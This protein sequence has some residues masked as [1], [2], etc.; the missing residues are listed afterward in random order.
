MELL[1][2]SEKSDKQSFGRVKLSY[3]QALKYSPQNNISCLGENLFEPEGILSAIKTLIQVNKNPEAY[4]S[5]DF[6]SG[7]DKIYDFPSAPEYKDVDI[8]S[9]LEDEVSVHF[10]ELSFEML[11][12]DKYKDEWWVPIRDILMENLQDIPSG[13]EVKYFYGDD[14]IKGSRVSDIFH[15]DEEPY[16]MFAYLFGKELKIFSCFVNTNISINCYYFQDRP[17]VIHENF[18]LW[19]GK[20]SDFLLSAELLSDAISKIP[21]DNMAANSWREKM[22]YKLL[23]EV[24]LM[25]PELGFIS[26]EP[27]KKEFKPSLTLTDFKYNIPQTLIISKHAEDCLKGEDLAHM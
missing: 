5:P 21:R 8:E 9:I 20:L 4:M 25:H 26:M 14:T 1:Q 18:G 6:R 12:S 27:G 2:I 13:L 7:S 17:Y 15:E 19:K 16:Q 11:A 3:D 22:F 24:K 10:N 23:G